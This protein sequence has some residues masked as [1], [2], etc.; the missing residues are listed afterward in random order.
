[1]STVFYITP[2]RKV[3]DI[4]VRSAKDRIFI[5]DIYESGI[6]NYD[7]TVMILDKISSPDNSWLFNTK[8]SN[9]SANDN[10]KTSVELIQ[11]YLAATD[12][13]DS[14]TDIYNPCNC[15]FVS[16]EDQNVITSRLGLSIKV[17]V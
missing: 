2:S 14:I 7:S 5:I 13:A 15:P 1:M 17:R 9:S 8:P 6:A 16:E 3:H 11:S 10:F 12:T 4:N